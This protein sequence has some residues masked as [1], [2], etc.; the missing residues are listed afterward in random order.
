MILDCLTLISRYVSPIGH[1]DVKVFEKLGVSKPVMTGFVKTLSSLSSGRF[2]TPSSWNPN[3]TLIFRSSFNVPAVCLFLL[4][5]KFDSKEES[6]GKS[7]L[8]R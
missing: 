1:V 6:D 8:R 3:S 5:F 2:S 4:G 7:R